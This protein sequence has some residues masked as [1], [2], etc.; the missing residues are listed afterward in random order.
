[1]KNYI[2]IMI[3]VTVMM[4]CNQ[5]QSTAEKSTEIAV[6]NETAETTSSKSNSII[7]VGPLKSAIVETETVMPEGMGSVVM[8]VTF[9]DMGKKKITE[10][11][12][13]LSRGGQKFK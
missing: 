1:M 12:T 4:S 9:D 13:S 8:K 10:L 11:N 5:K 7:A 3:A 2:L 6:N